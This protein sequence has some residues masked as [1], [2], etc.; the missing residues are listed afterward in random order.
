MKLQRWG[1]GN[2]YCVGEC[3]DGDFVRYEDCAALEAENEA[4]KADLLNCLGVEAKDSRSGIVPV[5]KKLWAQIMEERDAL[6]AENE[7]LRKD[8]ARLDW[9]ESEISAG[10][11]PALVFDDNKF[12]AV[13]MEGIQ[14]SITGDLPK[15]YEASIYVEAKAQRETVRE[16]IDVAMQEEE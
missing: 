10:G 2:P 8:K 9:F 6:K 13:S 15:D 11:C 5:N 3:E 12:W 14:T 1:M 4:L 16:A 7:V